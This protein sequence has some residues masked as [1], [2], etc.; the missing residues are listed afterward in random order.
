VEY[1][2]EDAAAYEALRVLVAAGH[3]IAFVGAGI[4]V[5]AEFPSWRGLLNKL[6]DEVM[7]WDDT[8]TEPVP[9]PK[10]WLS[11]ADRLRKHLR[12]AGPEI[13]ANAFGMMFQRLPDIVQVPRYTYLRP[14]HRTLVRLPFAG[15]TTTNYDEVLEH[16]I[17]DAFGSEERPGATPN[18]VCIYNGNTPHLSGAI[19]GMVAPLPQ[20]P[21]VAMPPRVVI[22][23]HG[24][25]GSEATIVLG[26]RDYEEAY[27][28]RDL[29]PPQP[30]SV[31]SGPAAPVVTRLFTAMAAL[32]TTRQVVFWGFSLEDP[33]VVDVLAR[34]SNVLWDWGRTVHFAVLP[35][36]VGDADDERRQ[37][38]VAAQRLK[39][40]GV[41][42][43]WFPVIDN[44]FRA[45]EEFVERL[46][47]EIP[48][49]SVDGGTGPSMAT[50]LQA[51]ETEAMQGPVPTADGAQALVTSP[52]PAWLRHAT[53]TFEHKGP[54]DAD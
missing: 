2:R 39:K 21:V 48:S 28:F 9:E 3:A 54:R 36:H 17:E 42:P 14:F 15:W 27:G 24:T 45:L 1:A 30:G 25:Y 37:R 7:L 44:D 23:W 53:F 40:L 11:Y 46:A 43:V 26:A 4:S 6:R 20:D 52:V 47:T 35:L 51:N 32:L 13:F 19:R 8:F 41:R 29:V 5:Q 50:P 22:H 31:H 18:T 33:Y 49:R 34:V 16:A 12:A 10:D 38:D